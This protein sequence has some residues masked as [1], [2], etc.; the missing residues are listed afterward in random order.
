M[1]NKV[2][3]KHQALALKKA[4]AMMRKGKK[5]F[6]YYHEACGAFHI[7]FTLHRHPQKMEPYKRLRVSQ[8]LTED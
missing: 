8:L 4:K 5:K 1:C 6:V 3:Y 2:S 7:G